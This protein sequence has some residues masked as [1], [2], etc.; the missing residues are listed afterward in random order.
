MFAANT[1]YEIMTP[2]GWQDFRGVLCSGKKP[3]LNIKLED[4]N[5]VNATA[6]HN[7]FVGGVKTKAGDLKVGDRI[8][9]TSIPV[10]IIEI[11]NNEPTFV[12]DI[13]EVSDINHHFI[14]NNSIKTTNCDELAFV[15]PSIANLFWTSITPT[16]ATGGKAIVTSTPNSDED[17][18]AQIW[19]QANKCVDEF[20]NPTLLGVNGFRAYTAK[21]QDHPDRDQKWADEMQATLGEE[22]FRREI[23]CVHGTSVISIKFPNG[24]IKSLT[25]LELER[26]LKTAPIFDNK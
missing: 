12:Y 13:V 16:L 22:K 25:I 8:E 6:Q 17:Q 15:R 19:K 24:E 21:W 20:G 23:E 7:F 1:D 10:K 3:T 11:T 26:L 5:E 14:A 4:G 18:F 2:T 9:T